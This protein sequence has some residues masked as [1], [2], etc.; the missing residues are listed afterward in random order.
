[1]FQINYLEVKHHVK[2]LTWFAIII[3]NFSLSTH[4]TLTLNMTLTLRIM[5]PLL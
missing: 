4:K 1:M 2:E 5:K 3:F